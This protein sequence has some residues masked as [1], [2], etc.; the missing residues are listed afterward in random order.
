MR[1]KNQASWTIPASLLYREELCASPVSKERLLNLTSSCKACL[2]DP[3]PWKTASHLPPS[4]KL[5]CSFCENKVH[6]EGV[7]LFIFFIHFN[8]F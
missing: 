7:S 8:Y 2:Q 4:P 6:R 1:S 3:S 5:K